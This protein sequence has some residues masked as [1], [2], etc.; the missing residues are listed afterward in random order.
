MSEKLCQ[1]TNDGALAMGSEK[2][3]VKIMVLVDW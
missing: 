3:L 2:W 1:A